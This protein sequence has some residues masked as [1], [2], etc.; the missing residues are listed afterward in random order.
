MSLDELLSLK[1]QAYFRD[2]ISVDLQKQIGEAVD[3]KLPGEML[4]MTTLIQ[5]A[6]KTEGESRMQKIQTD[7]KVMHVKRCQKFV[8]AIADL[9]RKLATVE[10]TLAGVQQ[11]KPQENV[12]V[13]KKKLA[14]IEKSYEGLQARIESIEDTMNGIWSCFRSWAES[15]QGIKKRKAALNDNL[16]P[17]NNLT[18]SAEQ[19]NTL[20]YDNKMDNGNLSSVSEKSP[21]RAETRLSL[22]QEQSHTQKVQ[23]ASNSFTPSTSSLE[24]SISLDV[25]QQVPVAANNTMAFS[26]P[27]RQLIESA[28]ESLISPE[29]TCPSVGHEVTFDMFSRPSEPKSATGLD[30]IQPRKSKSLAPVLKNETLLT[31][32]KTTS[33]K[34]ALV[35]L[36]EDILPQNRGAT[37]KNAD[38]SMMKEIRSSQASDLHIS[39]S[40]MS[41]VPYSTAQTEPTAS[42]PTCKS[43]IAIGASMSMKQEQLP[44]A[45]TNQSYSSERNTKHPEKEAFNEATRVTEN[46][47]VSCVTSRKED[48]VTSTWSVLHKLLTSAVNANRNGRL[49]AFFPKFCVQRSSC[50][51]FGVA[52]EDF[53]IATNSNSSVKQELKTDTS[54]IVNA[55]V[56]TSTQYST[57]NK[58]TLQAQER[59]DNQTMLSLLREMEADEDEQKSGNNNT[60]HNFLTQDV[61][62]TKSVSDVEMEDMRSFLTLGL[63]TTPVKQRTRTTANKHNGK[64]S[65]KKEGGVILKTK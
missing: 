59:G 1:L 6:V 26:T 48:A 38:S 30:S 10:A 23:S 41:C 36:T 15:S 52:A 51:D 2:T 49:P 8:G 20:T 58:L 46:E 18:E 21:S 61:D 57:G 64:K 60:S 35:S 47:T 65:R 62:T 12:E 37:P 55:A 29:P 42:T 27:G 63:P 5:H 25:P 11:A 31:D 40:V 13:L 17:K 34:P 54:M 3:S 9:D 56:N 33:E 4:K 44:N 53:S 16:H 32:D 7:Q 45:M 19:S 43:E 22:V 24:H 14:I 28:A 50:V 39:P